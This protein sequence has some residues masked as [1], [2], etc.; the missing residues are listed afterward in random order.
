MKTL[1]K[2]TTN[3]NYAILTPGGEVLK[4]SRRNQ[5]NYCKLTGSDAA[6]YWQKISDRIDVDFELT[7]EHVIN[8]YFLTDELEK[9]Q[10]LLKKSLNKIDKKDAEILE[11]KREVEILGKYKKH[12]GALPEYVVRN[13]KSE[14]KMKAHDYK[15]LLKK[16]KLQYKLKTLKEVEEKVCVIYTTSYAGKNGGFKHFSRSIDKTSALIENI[17]LWNRNKNLLVTDLR[18]KVI[19]ERGNISI[20]DIR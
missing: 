20:L 15:K 17:N 14:E 19:I 3:G 4:L 11:L 13:F 18:G 10:Y 16:Y 8:E 1:A 12:F 2:Q 9:S 5:Y 7:N 6:E